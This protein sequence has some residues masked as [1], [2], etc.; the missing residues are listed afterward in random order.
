MSPRPYS[1]SCYSNALPGVLHDT[2]LSAAEKILKVNRISK[3]S[4]KANFGVSLGVVALAWEYTLFFLPRKTAKRRHT[5]NF[6]INI[7]ISTYPTYVRILFTHE[8]ASC[9]RSWRTSRTSYITPI[10]IN[11]TSILTLWD[12]FFVERKQI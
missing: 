3:R 6:P 10:L 12:W 9:P 7:P 1:F 11:E 5:T 4:F 8:D 2:L